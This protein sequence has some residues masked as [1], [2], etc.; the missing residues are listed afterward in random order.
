MPKRRTDDAVYIVMTDHFIRARQP[1]GDLTA[2][3]KETP[4][5]ETPPYRGEVVPY[6]PKNMAS[7]TTP[8]ARRQEEAELYGALSQIVEHSNMSGGVPLLESLVHKYK[9]VQADFY[10]DLADGITAVGDV[11][12]G[13]QYYEE[14]AQHAPDS[15]L[16]LRRLGSARMDAGQLPG[17]EAT[18]RRVTT[19]TP[20]DSGAWGMLAQVV[21][22]QG[23]A[24]EAMALFRRSIAIDPEVPEIHISLGSL[25]L[26]GGDGAGAEKEYR[27]ALRIEPNLPQAHMNLASMLASRGKAFA[28]EA[29]FHFARS[30]ELKPDYAEAR[31]NYARLLYSLGEADEA[32]KQVS[33]SVAT[34]GRV[35]EAHE[36]WGLLL[37]NKNDLAGAV[38]EFG[39][40][41]KLRPDLWS[42]QYELGVALGKNRDFAGAEEHLKL[43]AGGNDPEVK[44][45][46]EN[47]LQRLA[48]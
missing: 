40:A 9:P 17:A 38:R 4:E 46:A 32:E 47:I 16:I 24:P 33:A 6:Y 2:A 1:A 28:A 41:V 27:E 45:A 18:L 29:R 26:A 15:A 44:A 14:A 11:A 22:R 31:L 25:L 35:P 23:R 39:E 12:K 8:P 34:D 5:S 20:E 48:R 30:I 19:L 36:L 10:A 7:T 3:K 13:L 43:A 21:M 37:G 42:A